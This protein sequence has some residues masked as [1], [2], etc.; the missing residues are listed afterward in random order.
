MSCIVCYEF[1]NHCTH[2]TK[3]LKT[4]LIDSTDAVYGYF[5]ISYFR[6]TYILLFIKIYNIY[7]VWLNFLYRI[8]E[9]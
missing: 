8:L 4:N 5:P 2:V 6:V 3:G 9:A 1:L 7:A